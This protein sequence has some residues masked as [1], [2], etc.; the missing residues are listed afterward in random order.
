MP[1]YLDI[2]SVL[3]QEVNT[4]FMPGDYLPA[5]SKLA[6]RF[7]VNRHTLR[8]AIDELVNSGMI[9]RHQGKGNL[10]VRQPNPYH[11]HSAAHFTKNLI[12]QGAQP[13]CEVLLSRIISAPLTVATKL[14]VSEG[15]R[16]IHIRT[17][18]RTQDMPRTIIDHYLPKTDW[19]PVLKNFQSGSLHQFIKRG[20]EVELER[21]ETSVGA[22]APTNEE[23]R[24]L[25]IPATTPI[26]KI[27]TKN[28]IKG[29]SIVAEFSHSNSRSD[30]TEI[31]ME[32]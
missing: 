23:C 24:L 31:V 18:R 20:L 2:A 22:R 13:R 14:N 3:E 25:Q 28:V 6:K 11:I 1:V 19:W 7:E 21:K 29:T 17:L 26:L 16:I 8:R 32:H 4:S 10:V 15:Q 5:E 30:A 27:K 9:Q 12:E